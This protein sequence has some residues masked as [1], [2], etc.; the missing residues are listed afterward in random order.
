VRDCCNNV[1]TGCYNMLDK[2]RSCD[3]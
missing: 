1:I 2:F 3:H